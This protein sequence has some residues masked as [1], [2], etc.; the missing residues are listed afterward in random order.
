MSTSGPVVEPMERDHP[1]ALIG[2]TEPDALRRI[3]AMDSQFPV[4]WVREGRALE[5]S[6]CAG[7][8]TVIVHGGRVVHAGWS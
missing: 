8:L 5:L 4:R 6:Y 1:E 7:R 2:L 3:E